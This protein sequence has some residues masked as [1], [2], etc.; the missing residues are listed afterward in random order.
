[1][2]PAEAA[3]VL[4]TAVT[5]DARLSPPSVED[6]VVRA[7]AWAAALDHDLDVTVAREIVIDHYRNNTTCLM[8]AHV[9]EEWRRI[10]RNAW[11]AEMV[12]RR[13]TEIE[14]Q[15]RVSTPMPVSVREAYEAVLRK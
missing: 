8:P 7:Q 15:R 6:G 9:N 4:A 11:A 2:T 12:D 10:R 3:T 5:F 1:M 14:Q 13:G